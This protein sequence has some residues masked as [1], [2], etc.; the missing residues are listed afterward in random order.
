MNVVVIKGL[1]KYGYED[2]AAEATEKYLAG[3]HEVFKKTQ[4][5]YENYAPEHF[6]PGKPAK[7]DFVGWTGCGPIQLLFENVMGLRPDGAD[8][9]LIW[10]LRR[11]DQHGVENL[12]LGK[13]T[14]S[15]ICEERENKNAPANIVVVCDLPFHL[16]VIHPLGEKSF[17]LDKGKH[18]LE[19]MSF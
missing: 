9:T 3:M 17:K 15:V 7:A 10:E 1:E 8:N 14:V 4:T 16:K 11:I 2:F 6:E 13:S 12:K 19:I 5:V 18:L